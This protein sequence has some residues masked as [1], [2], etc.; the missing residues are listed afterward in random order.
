MRNAPH[1]MSVK[2]HYHTHLLKLYDDNVWHLNNGSKQY[3]RTIWWTNT[4][5]ALN[6]TTND[7]SVTTK[8]KRGATS[9]RLTVYRWRVK[10]LYGTH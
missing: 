6:S 2:G 5:R 9:T 3:K 1:R 4:I 10:C 7:S 8:T